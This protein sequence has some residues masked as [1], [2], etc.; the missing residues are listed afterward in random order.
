MTE[1]CSEPNIQKKPEIKP[2]RLVSLLALLCLEVF[3][4]VTFPEFRS[5]STEEKNT[6]T[7]VL[8]PNPTLSAHAYLVQIIGE[9]APL[10]KQRAWKPVPPASITKLLTA[11]LARKILP[12][13]YTITISEETK[14]IGEKMSTLEIGTQLSRDEA[15]AAMLVESTNDIAYALGNTIVSK[16]NP[17]TEDKENVLSDIL[18]ERSRQL[19]MKNTKFHNATGLDQDG[20]KTSAEDLFILAQYL[21]YNDHWIWDITKNSEITVQTDKGEYKAISTNLLLQ[22]F[23]ALRGGKTGLTDSAKGTLILLYPL[24]NGK[25]AVIVILGSEDRFEDGRKIIHWLKEIEV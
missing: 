12:E 6:T 16:A 7:V 21:W 10:L 14:L 13:N 24:N 11:H 19:G 18:G 23:P 2:I 20:H 5:P 25:I 1:I 4:L 17:F 9:T 8:P 15:I 22:E 3:V